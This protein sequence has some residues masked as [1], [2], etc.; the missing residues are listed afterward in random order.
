MA[1]LNLNKVILAGRITADPE[2]KTTQ[3]G[4]SV[5]TFTVAVNR[6]KPKDGG[7]AMS[8]FIT[9]VAWKERA[10]MIGKYFNK[11]SS[12]L[13]E[14]EINVRKWQDKDGGNRYATEVQVTR[15][16]FVDSKNEGQGA[17]AASSAPSYTPDAYKA[18]QFGEMGKD[19]DLPF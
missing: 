8:D 13:I 3:S 1:N 9:C 11:G 4:T 12:I 5:L 10:E 19:D 18:P 15:V 17:P 7:E 16:Y 6:P 14:G 2:V